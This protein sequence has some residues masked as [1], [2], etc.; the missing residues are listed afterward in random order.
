MASVGADLFL[1]N[2]DKFYEINYR[3]DLDGFFIEPC[4]AYSAKLRDE[5]T[6]L[7][8]FTRHCLGSMSYEAVF[9]DKSEFSHDSSEN[10][11]KHDFR[12]DIT[13]SWIKIA[14]YPL[15]F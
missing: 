15:F 4:P 6:R 10:I 12:M 13:V 11:S 5:I 9:S 7:Q 3:S 2:K 1:L 8:N 14:F